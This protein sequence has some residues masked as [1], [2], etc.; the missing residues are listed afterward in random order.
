M[1]I[2]LNKNKNFVMRYEI[3]Y[4]VTYKN[5]N[6]IIK[7]E[8]VCSFYTDTTFRKA[9]ECIRCLFAAG[10]R[11]IREERV[12]WIRWKGTVNC[13]NRRFGQFLRNSDAVYDVLQG[14]AFVWIYV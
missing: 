13:R 6:A 11:G 8:E 3:K 10:E 1:G 12:F 9:G 7:L 4:T 2:Y 14:T 5:D